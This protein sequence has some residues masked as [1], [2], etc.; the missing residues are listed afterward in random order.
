[1]L[2]IEWKDLV[3]PVL[4]SSRIVWKDKFANTDGL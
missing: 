4:G 2:N 3:N 1:M